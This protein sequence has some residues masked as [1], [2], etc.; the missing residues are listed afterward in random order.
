MTI[1]YF[2]VQTR[3]FYISLIRTRGGTDMLIE[4][5]EWE[6]N[7]LLDYLN[8]EA[9]Y[10]TGREPKVLALRDKI[11]VAFETSGFKRIELIGD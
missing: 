1:R 5:D 11:H 3:S 10:T 9:D 6:T 8:E 7:Y 4:L 2:A